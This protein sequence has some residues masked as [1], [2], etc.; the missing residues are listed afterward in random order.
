MIENV[1]VNDAY[2]GHRDQPSG[3]LRGS[4]F[5]IVKAVVANL[6]IG[7]LYRERY[8]VEDADYDHDHVVRTGRRRRI[9]DRYVHLNGT[10]NLLVRLVE[11]AS[12]EQ[13]IEMPSVRDCDECRVENKLFPD[14]A[15]FHASLPR[16]E[17]AFARGDGKG[18][19]NDDELEEICIVPSLTVDG[20]R[21]SRGRASPSRKV[22]RVG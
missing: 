1:T 13:A 4:Y 6:E 16:P 14:Y 22:G 3:W 9:V 15:R 19:V 2:G 10:P 18:V 7:L 8:C 11:T 21:H 17:V 5:W 20:S 12:H